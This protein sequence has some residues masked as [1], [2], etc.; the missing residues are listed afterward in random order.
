MYRI[1]TLFFFGT[2]FTLCSCSLAPFSPTNSARSLGKGGMQTQAGR[3]NNS[4]FMKYAIGLSENFDAGFVTEFGSISTSAIFAKYAITN[5]PF[6]FS[7]GIEGGYGS[8]DDTQ[9]YYIGSTAS[10]AFGEALEFFIN[11]RLNKANTEEGNIEAGDRNGN[12][13]IL[14]QDLTYLQVAYG[15]NLWLGKKA[16]ISLFNTHFRGDDIET[17]QDAVFGAAFLYRL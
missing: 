12:L 8:S 9:F 11:G 7:W 16:G 1:Q 15:M 4:F 14:E 13:T 17:T 6:G 5:N 3:A 2:L 10:Y